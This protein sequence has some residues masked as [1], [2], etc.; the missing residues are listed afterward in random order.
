MPFLSLFQK[1]ALIIGL[2]FTFACFDCKITLSLAVL[3]LNDTL[4]PCANI[5]KH[6]TLNHTL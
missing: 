1:S 3:V 6:K 5:L 2:L 4:C